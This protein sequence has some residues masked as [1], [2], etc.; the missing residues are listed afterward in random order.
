MEKYTSNYK[1]IVIQNNDPEKM[2]R[3]KVFVPEVNINLFENWTSDK[4]HDKQFTFLGKNIG[5]SITP[6]ILLRLKTALPWAIIKHPVFGMS[7]NGFYDSS[8]DYWE[9]SNDSNASKQSTQINREVYETNPSNSQSGGVIYPPT[10]VKNQSYN[11]GSGGSD[12]FN[13]LTTSI[14]TSSQVLSHMIGSVNIMSLMGNNYGSKFDN[15][16]DPNK[17]MG[18]NQQLKADYL[19]HMISNTQGNKVKGIISIPGIGSH[20]SVY[21]EQGDPLYPIIDGVFYTKEDVSGLHDIVE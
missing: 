11:M 7:V 1:G 9:I 12:M 21:F 18:I 13:I 16:T 14:A 17:I 8:D 3:V 4:E 5:S 19:P 20:V 15:F 2:G 10:I 6:E